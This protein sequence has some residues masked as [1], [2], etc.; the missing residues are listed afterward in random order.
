MPGS[1]RHLT[2][3]CLSFLLLVEN[4]YSTFCLDTKSGAKKSRQ[5]QMLRW[6]CHGSRT[7][8][9]TSR[10]DKLQDLLLSLEGIAH[11][12]SETC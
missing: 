3:Y 4:V 6:I 5:I 12:I 10:Q 7:S 9:I 8:S 11:S 1:T 2:N